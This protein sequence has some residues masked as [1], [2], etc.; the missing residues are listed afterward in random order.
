VFVGISKPSQGD[1]Q[2]GVTGYSP[3]IRSGTAFRADSNA[4][5]TSLSD[6]QQYRTYLQSLVEQG[7]HMMHEVAQVWDDD[8]HDSYQHVWRQIKE[9]LS[10]FK[11]E[12]G[13]VCSHLERKIQETQQGER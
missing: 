11:E 5:E 3:T 2:I 10:Q 8:I 9:K 1:F 6:L 4:L 13:P 12:L 7:E